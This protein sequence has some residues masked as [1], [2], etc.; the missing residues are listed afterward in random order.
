MVFKLIIGDKGK[1]WRL[2]IEGE[3]LVGKSIGEK[4]DG[5]EIS[6]ALSGYEL[7]ITGGS[8]F[9]GFPMYKEVEGIGLK[10]VLFTK[11]GWGMWDNREGIR[12]RKTIRG[13]QISDKTV[14]INMKI[15][16]EGGNKLSEIFPEQN[17]ASEKVEKKSKEE[18]KAETVV[19]T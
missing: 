11:K 4:V 7:E 18:K 1:A 10:R 19:A 16:K 6:S 14:Q 17:K 3:G 8:D 9:A 15:L 13:K 5:K 2:E 12:L